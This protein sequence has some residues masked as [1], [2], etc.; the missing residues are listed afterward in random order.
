MNQPYPQTPEMPS[1]TH[2]R[3]FYISSDEHS[4]KTSQDSIAFYEQVMKGKDYLFIDSRQNIVDIL[5]LVSSRDK[6]HIDLGYNYKIELEILFR[7][8]TANYRDVSVTLRNEIMI[9]YPFREFKNPFLNTLSKL[10]DRY[11][12]GFRQVSPYIR[13]IRSIYVLSQQELLLVKKRYRV[14]QV[15]LLPLTVSKM[16]GTPGVYIK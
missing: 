9:K 14:E 10:F 7:M 16:D 6:V 15:Y 3:S 1:H 13:K 8:L 12:T 11:I 4:S 5:S 2:P